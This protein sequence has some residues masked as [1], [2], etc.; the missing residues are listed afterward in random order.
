MAA[1]RLIAL[2]VVLL[3][4]SSIAA[5]LAP[6]PAERES[7]ETSTTGTETTETGATGHQAP[8]GELLELTVD[9]PPARDGEARK[10]ARPQT[11]GAAVG[12]QLAL[13]VRSSETTEVEIP[14]LG[15]I[16]T[17][18]AGGPARFD[19]LLREPG[20]YA[21]LAGGGRQIAWIVVAAPQKPKG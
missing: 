15:L 2:L 11:I 16:E 20:R 21:V 8:T 18:T 14:E 1:R 10:P 7:G 3:V 13:T 6:T 4:I 5:A 12:D 17:A 19:L 9:V